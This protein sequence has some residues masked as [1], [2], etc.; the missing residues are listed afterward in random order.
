MPTL[1]DERICDSARLAAAQEELSAA[2]NAALAAAERPRALL[3]EQADWLDARDVAARR[4]DG[5]LERL[6]RRRTEELWRRAD[7]G[8][9]GDEDASFWRDER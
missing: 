3:R 2:Y 4:S 9:V 8:R 1:A 7:Q 6:Y 5:A